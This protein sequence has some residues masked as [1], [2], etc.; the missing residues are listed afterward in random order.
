MS[1]HLT[2][3]VTIKPTQ[4][5][6]IIRNC[7]KCGGKSTYINTESFRVNANGNA[8]DIWLIY[9]CERCKTTYNLSI[10]E[11]IRPKSLPLEEYE[12]YLSNN[13]EL[14]WRVSYDGAV[15][16]RNHVEIDMEKECYSMEVKESSEANII[17]K[18]ND[19]DTNIIGIDNDADTN[20]IEQKYQQIIQI[21]NPYHIRFRMDRILADLLGRSRTEIKK[22]FD[23]GKIVSQPNCKVNK[24]CV[25]GNINVHIL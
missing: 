23:D 3:E 13:Q 11:R 17:E 21:H 2:K 5:Q 18:N 9:Q 20:M 22:W 1:Y 6:Q 15:L 14:A 4:G 19:S 25:Q 8:I 7:S 16:K 24:A 12:E 10:H